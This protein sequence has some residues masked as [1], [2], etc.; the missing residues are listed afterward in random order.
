MKAGTLLSLQQGLRSWGLIMEL[1][2]LMMAFGTLP[3]PLLRICQRVQQS[4]IASMRCVFII[5]KRSFPFLAYSSHVWRH[6]VEWRISLKI[7][8]EILNTHI[9][10]LYFIVIVHWCQHVLR[11]Q[12]L[13]AFRNNMKSRLNYFFL[14]II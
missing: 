10:Y 6:T 1:Y 12:C 9:I 5:F 14:V 13:V 8:N 3:L 7:D 11:W 4:S 2:Q